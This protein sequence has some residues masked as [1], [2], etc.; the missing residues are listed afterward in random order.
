[1]YNQNLDVMFIYSPLNL[2]LVI[3]WILNFK[4]IL[5]LL[6]IWAP[7]GGCKSSRSPPGGGLLLLVLHVGAFLPRFFLRGTFFYHVGPF[8][9]IFLSIWEI[10]FV[11][12]ECLFATLV[13]FI[14]NFFCHVGALPL[15]FLHMGA[16]FEHVPP[17]P[18]LRIFFAGSHVVHTPP[19]TI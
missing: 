15:L 1:M 5:F 16:F 9:Y 6:L 14:S 19:H 7:A 2:D 3:L 4:V 13:S 11:V 10:L 18:P 17:P 12:M 8:Y